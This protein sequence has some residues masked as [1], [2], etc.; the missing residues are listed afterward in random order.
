MTCEVIRDLLPLCA[1]GVASEESRAAVEE[2]IRTCDECRTLY[3]SMC[4]PVEA[5][6]APKE[7]DYMD[8]VRQ[9]KKENRRF[10]LRV[11]GV[12]VAVLLLLLVGWKVRDLLRIR[13]GYLESIPIT[14]EQVA[15]ELPQALLTRAEKDL[16]K[17]IFFLPEVQDAF[18]EGQA[19]AVGTYLPEELYR[20]LMI[21]A[22]FDPDSVKHGYADIMG[23]TVVLDWYS[24]EYRCCLEFIDADQSGHAD[25]LRKTTTKRVP[26]VDEN[27]FADTSNRAPIY[28]VEI[29]AASIGLYPEDAEKNEL[30]ESVSTTC[31][32]SV[33]KRDWLYFLKYD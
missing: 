30:S 9:Q 13:A 28:T 18:E 14:S 19:A 20:E 29:N 15:K 23:R 11:Y 33:E 31:E 17:V 4:K 7:P 3:E 5:Q 10:V 26:K 12:T 6:E 25:I 8:A 1:D 16:A 22:G 27:G 32:K 2:H 24:D 21:Q